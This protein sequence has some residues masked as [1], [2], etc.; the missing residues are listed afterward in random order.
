VQAET[1]APLESALPRPA[2]RANYS[3]RCYPVRLGDVPL[4]RAADA[5]RSHFEVRE[6][7]VT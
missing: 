7:G 6:A 4:A 1:P 5:E 2:R 3:N